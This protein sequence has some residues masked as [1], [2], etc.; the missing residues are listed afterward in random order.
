[1][2]LFED[3][4]P[5]WHRP[6]D[7]KPFSVSDA[8]RPLGR[9]CEGTLVAILNRF[10]LFSKGSRASSGCRSNENDCREE[11]F[12]VFMLIHITL[13]LGETSIVNLKLEGGITV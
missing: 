4:N 11:G 2:H 1:M 7:S 8:R 9:R 12:A 3:D 13:H 6:W 10:E 5:T